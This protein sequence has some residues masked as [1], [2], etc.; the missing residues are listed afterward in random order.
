M[1][2]DLPEINTW[3]FPICGIE[4]DSQT[5]DEIR[6]FQKNIISVIE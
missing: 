4:N 6:I 3:I 2:D 5:D 1:D